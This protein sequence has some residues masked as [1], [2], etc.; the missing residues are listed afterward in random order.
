MSSLLSREQQPVPPVRTMGPQ[1]QAGL[2]KPSRA[3]DLGV[4]C[5]FI[6]GSRGFWESPV[7]R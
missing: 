2:E 4:A 6:A 7:G 1:V 3:E 5:L